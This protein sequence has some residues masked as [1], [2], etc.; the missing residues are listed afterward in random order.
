MPGLVSPRDEEL[1][2]GRP[3]YRSLLET[4]VRYGAMGR[5]LAF[6]QGQLEAESRARLELEGQMGALNLQCEHMAARERRA[7]E[8]KRAAEEASEHAEESYLMLKATRAG[9]RCVTMDCAHM[10]DLGEYDMQHEIYS[11][12]RRRDASFDPV[13][14]SLPSKLIDPESPTGPATSLGTSGTGV[15]A[16]GDPFLGLTLGLGGAI[17]TALDQIHIPPGMADFAQAADPEARDP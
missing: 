2:Q 16:G 11:G 17:D 9:K 3:D 13:A 6:T 1:C 12:L 4:V 14:W 10:H 5:A 15:V 7:L 8:E